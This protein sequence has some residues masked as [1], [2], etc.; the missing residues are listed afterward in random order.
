MSSIQRF[1]TNHPHRPALG[2]CVMTRKPICGE[3]STRYEGV[4]YSREGLEQLKAQRAAALR[5]KNSWRARLGAIAAW[6]AAP[7]AL[8]LIYLAYLLG[9]DLLMSLLHGER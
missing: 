2:V 4:N 3:C 9:S 1:C 5:R 7:A 8:Y 6:L